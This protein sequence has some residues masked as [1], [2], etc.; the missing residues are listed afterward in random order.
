MNEELVLNVPLLRRRVPNL[1]VAARS[2]GLRSATVSDLC[3][4][5]IPVG[6]AEVRTLSALASL[7]GCSIDELILRGGLAGFLET[8]IKALDLLAPMVRGGTVGCVARS[9]VGQLVLLAE[10]MNRLREQRDFATILWLPSDGASVS[11]RLFAKG[12]DLTSAA[13]VTCETRE[14]VAAAVVELGSRRDVLLVAHQETVL[15]GDLFQLRE[16]VDGPGN[17]PLTVALFGGES[18]LDEEAPFGPLDTLWRF[19]LDLFARGLFPAID[20]IASTSVLT[21]GAQLEASHL[22][23]A[24]RARSLLRRY[25]D[26]RV[27]LKVRQADK[28]SA[29]DQNALRRGERLEAFMS[30]PL[31]VAE[32]MTSRPGASASLAETLDGVRRILDGAADQIAPEELKYIGPLV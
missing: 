19:D 4:G 22:T 18:A 8:G 10:I 29:S 9:G 30:Q 13:E 11:L 24:T 27:I 1:T 20:P 2:V 31:Y 28:L 6:R 7:A 25:R 23:L 14:E 3:T 26:L 21:E 32:E 15:S 5:K 17:R 12:G 16:A